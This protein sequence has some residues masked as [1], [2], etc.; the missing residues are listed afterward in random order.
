MP[1]DVIM[2]KLGLTMERATITRWLKGPGERVARGE[3]VLEIET[4]KATAEV[5]APAAGV[6]GEHLYPVRAD[7]PIGQVVVYILAEGDGLHPGRR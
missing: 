2:P 5:E 7:V 3:V 4:D 1:I 6:V